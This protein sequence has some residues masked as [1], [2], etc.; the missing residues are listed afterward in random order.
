MQIVE[1]HFPARARVAFDSGARDCCIF[2]QV[3]VLKGA[4]DIT[5]GTK[6][7]RLKQGD[8][9]AMQLDG[10]TMFHNPTPKPARYVVVMAGENVSTR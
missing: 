7:H 3:W 5:V 1:V 10:P 6:R 2:Q 9:L 4:M 8:C